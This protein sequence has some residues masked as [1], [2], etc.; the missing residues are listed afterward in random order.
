MQLENVHQEIQGYG[1]DHVIALHN[2]PYVPHLI[3]PDILHIP[4]NHLMHGR[5]YGKMSQ[6][7]FTCV[8]SRLPAFFY[9]WVCVI[10]IFTNFCFFLSKMWSKSQKNWRFA[11]FLLILNAFLTVAKSRDQFYANFVAETGKK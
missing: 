11:P 3:C 9:V 10:K 4:S 5:E 2:R 8:F 1:K 6:T 7:R